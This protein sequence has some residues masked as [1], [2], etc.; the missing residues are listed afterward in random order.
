MQ[1]CRAICFMAVIFSFFSFSGIDKPINDA[2][3]GIAKIYIY[4]V[5]QLS[6]AANNYT[7]FVDGEQF[8]KLS[9]NKYIVAE[10]S[11]GTHR[12]SAQLG[13]SVF[14]KEAEVEIDAK[15]G[16]SYYISCYV[17][18]GLTKSD[19]KMLEVAETTAQLQMK[20]MGKDNCRN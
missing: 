12:V 18:T 5:G 9:N 11:P 8:C 2:K 13:F 10:V 4:R 1:F 14:K 20:D 16:V 6:S 3:P 7:I 19:F 17:K 15:D